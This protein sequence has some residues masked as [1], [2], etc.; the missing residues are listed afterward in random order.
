LGGFL[1]DVILNLDP[2][3]QKMNLLRNPQMKL[4]V[5]GGIGSGKT[6]VCR[7]FKILGIPVFS[8]DIE[9]SKIM[10]TNSEII[11]SINSLVG[12]DLYVGGSLNRLKLASIIFK[13][14]AL[15]HKINSIVH[16]VV[17]DHF[18]LWANEQSAPYIIKEAAVL[19]ESGGS[20]MVDKVVSVIAPVDERIARV[21]KRNELSRDQVMDRIRNQMDDESRIKLS[22]YVIKNSEK[23]MII[24]EILKI[25][26]GILR[27][28]HYNI[29]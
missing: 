16:P 20:K 4:G 12:E 14:Q 18:K 6:S 28:L 5:T 25:H 11:R 3:R 17:F 2:N 27:H 23:D 22:D 10:D 19:F 26:E 29:A 15:L 9:A 21:I 8:A 13:N 1:L 7:V 24:P